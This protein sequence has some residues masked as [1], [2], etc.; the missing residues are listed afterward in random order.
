MAEKE[1]VS[2]A[3][4]VFKIN[5]QNAP[6]AKKEEET[7]YDE[8]KVKN[9]TAKQSEETADTNGFLEEKKPNRRRRSYKR[10][11]CCL[12][13][14]CGILLLGII[15]VCAYI[16]TVSQEDELKQLRE[17]QKT[18]LAEIRNLTNHTSKLSSDYENLKRDYSSLSVQLENLTQNYTVL[19]NKTSN[20]TEENQDLEK[21]N[22][23]LETERN[24]L[25]AQIHDMMTKDNVSRAQW[26]IDAYCPLKNNERRCKPCQDSWQHTKPSCYLYYNMVSGKGKT[27]KEAQENCTNSISSLAV[28]HN[29][30]EQDAISEHSYDSSETNGYWIGL[31]AEGGTWK[32]IDGNDL[33]NNF[34]EGPEPAAADGQCAVS[35]KKKGWISTHCDKRQKWMCRKKALSV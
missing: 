35:V 28:I 34:W 29:E 19:E 16:A 24:N 20:L 4:V 33:V 14:L 10:L 9:E 13:I 32:W 1:E 23:E 8:V 18:L 7:V 12:G 3:S 21:Q 11:A 27:W 2:Y 22:Q 15:G 25:T 17:S 5:N 31:K 6:E 26:S 30:D